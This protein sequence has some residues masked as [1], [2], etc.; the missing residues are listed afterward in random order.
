MGLEDTIGIQDEGETCIVCEKPVRYGTG[1]AHLKHDA[2]S[3]SPH[4]NPIAQDKTVE[5]TASVT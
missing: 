3:K 5:Q 4:G 2:S 1:F